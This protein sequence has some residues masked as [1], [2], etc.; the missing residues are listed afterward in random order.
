MPGLRPSLAW[1]RSV[2]QQMWQQ[3]LKKDR[4]WILRNRGFLLARLYRLGTEPDGNGEK[5]AIFGIP[6]R[7]MATRL[8]VRQS[9][10]L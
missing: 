9:A 2:L 1:P 5:T 6:R 8:P 3:G 7:E 4:D 10:Q